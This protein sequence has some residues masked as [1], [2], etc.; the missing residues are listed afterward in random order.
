MIRTP[1]H[2]SRN[3]IDTAVRGSRRKRIPELSTPAH[4]N[5]G[6]LCRRPAHARL[7]GVLNH[8][9]YAAISYTRSRPARRIARLGRDRG[10]LCCGGELDGVRRARGGPAAAVRR[11]IERRRR[12]SAGRRHDLTLPL[13]LTHH[14]A[15]ACIDRGR[16][17]PDATGDTRTA[18]RCT[19]LVARARSIGATGAACLCAA[20]STE[21]EHRASAVRDARTGT[22]Q[23][24]LNNAQFQAV[25][26]SRA[27][28]TPSTPHT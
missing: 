22:I 18:Q 9:V 27:G 7:Q 28:A 23:H 3:A 2:E 25:A 15:D 1:R 4:R 14:G 19:W 17:A 16:G 24:T 12:S 20:G 5:E 11:R 10:D 21:S 26:I 6:S 8:D 13:A